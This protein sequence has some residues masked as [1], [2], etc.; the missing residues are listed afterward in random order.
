MAEDKTTNDV[1]QALEK[2]IA[3][4]RGELKRLSRTLASQS[5]EFR[6]RAEDAM[7]DVSGRL[8]HTAQAVR[9]RGQVVA[10]TIR[11]NPG[12]ATTLFGTAGILGILIGVAIG[13]AISDRR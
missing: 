5:G 6:E 4:M 7:D 3:D 9:D 8:R 10:E 12:T 1:Q 2:Q 11:E 13:C